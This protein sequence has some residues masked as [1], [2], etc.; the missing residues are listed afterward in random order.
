[1]RI[2]GAGNTAKPWTVTSVK[3]KRTVESVKLSNP[4]SL[5]ELVAKKL[6]QSIRRPAKLASPRSLVQLAANKIEQSIRQPAKLPPSSKSKIKSLT[7][8][9]TNSIVKDRIKFY[10]N[11]ACKNGSVMTYKMMLVSITNM[12]KD[13][14]NKASASRFSPDTTFQNLFANR[15]N[16]MQGQRE[17]VQLT[18]KADVENMIGDRSMITR[19]SSR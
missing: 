17:K 11:L 12:R 1:M 15:L 5:T 4:K 7:E 6:E 2:L 16:K 9:A 13:E 18:I 3:P 10:E 19:K 14:L 8:L